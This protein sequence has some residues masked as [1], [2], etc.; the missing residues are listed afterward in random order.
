M[1]DD[2]LE[3]RLRAHY[4][5][6]DPRLA[7]RGLG[8]RIGDALERRQ[9]RPVFIA[10]TR[11]AFAAGLAA[12]VIVAVGLGLGLR[13][14]GFLASPGV[15]PTPTASPQ[16]SVPSSPGPDRRPGPPAALER[17]ADDPTLHGDAVGAPRLVA[18]P[19]GTFLMLKA[20]DVPGGG[21]LMRS[22]DGRTWDQVDA[23]AS[24]LD[25]GAI[26]DLAA[27][28]T[29]V[30]ILGTTE[31]MTGTGTEVPNVAEWTSTDGVTWTRAPDAGALRAIGARDIVGSS[32]GFAAM[33]D[34]P[35]TILLSGPDGRQWRQTELPVPPGARGSVSK[36]APTAD[37]FLAVGTVEGRSAAWRWDGTG[38]S[39]LP[40]GDTDS[41]SNVVANDERIIV[42][43]TMETPDPAKP[44]H[45]TLTTIAWQSTDGGT[46]W[47]SAGL[48]LDGITG[49]RV[50]A[51]DGGFLAVLSPPDSQDPLSA[52][53]SVRPGAWEPVT[54]GDGGRGWDRPFVAALALSGRRVVLAGNTVGTGAGGDRVVV[55]I[56]DTTA[57]QPSSPSPSASPSPARPTSQASGTSPA[58]T[59]LPP[60]PDVQA[61]GLTD[62]LHGWAV[63]GHRL[64]VTADGG[65][66]WRDVTPPV[67]FG[68][69]LGNPH[70]VAF[71]DAQHGWV[72]INEAFTSGSDP[73][74]GRVDIW[75]TSD[76]GQAWT[77]A[78]LPKAVRNQFGEIMPQV[79]FDFLDAGHG[80]AFLSGNSAKG[81]NDSD[82][83]WTADGGRTWS[84]DRPTGDGDLGIE[85]TI[86]FA[87]ANDGVIVN[88]LHGSGIVV[89][90]DGGMTWADAIFALP[91][92]SAG[93]QLFF[94]QPVYVDGRSGLVSI[95]FQIDT[96]SVAR[97]YRTSD[98]GS[99]WTIAATLPTG[100]SAIS[101]LDPQR[102]I[103]FNGS[104]VVRTVDGGQTWVR[105]PAVGPPGAPYSFL[106]ADAQHG[107][108][109]VGMNVCL[110]FKSNC[111]SRTGLYATVD[112]GSTWA[113]L[114]PK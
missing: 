55:W 93:A 101:F 37:G 11:S 6:I 15:S 7:P 3:Q 96:S 64:W 14:G 57:P 43:G 66:T 100:V 23:S 5:A 59:P 32:R 56:G 108:V 48:P 84:A 25:A 107:S 113:Q 1:T 29:A 81:R 42:S 2:E 105:S 53:R 49:L 50:F 91:P 94:G 63:V 27:N 80:F 89:T 106:M 90:H 31:P 87:T 112:G 35:L 10:R 52:W 75:R 74:Y 111:S 79:Q 67:G 38:W 68:S 104:E 58:P 70:G 82:L 97:V 36:V 88:A 95:D 102:W 77:K 99:S 44:D 16:P 46:T 47:T 39:R 109:L 34:A 40:L 17:V 72:A 73:S 26:V 76:G 110:T 9:R 85:G 98:A 92:G 19:G 24:G 65:S 13:P 4:R 62:P 45:P 54:L 86:G 12:V 28:E 41:I 8:V 114:W 103:G 33:G 20:E 22:D 18:L 51:M 30:V 71:L 61:G 83:F 78:Q 69:G 21:V 60:G